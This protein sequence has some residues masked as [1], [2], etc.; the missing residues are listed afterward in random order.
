MD[1]QKEI[2]KPIQSSTLKCGKRTFFFDCYVASNS[3]KYLKITE[4][5]F[6]E[7]GQDRK[8]NS[9][10]LF[11]EDVLNFQQRVEEIKGYLAE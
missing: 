2:R 5:R 11:P 1:K 9:F 4:S 3:K 10:I 6:V 8:R 7:E